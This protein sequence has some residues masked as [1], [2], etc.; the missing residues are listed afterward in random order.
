MKIF[1]TGHNNLISIYHADKV[2]NGIVKINGVNNRYNFYA[3][4]KVY[5]E[6]GGSCNQIRIDDKIDYIIIDNGKIN[7][8]SAGE[9]SKKNKAKIINGAFDDWTEEELDAYIKVNSL[10][11]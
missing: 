11:D 8:I 9:S 1:I 4:K 7:D 3:N 2:N 6:V 10:E 5:I